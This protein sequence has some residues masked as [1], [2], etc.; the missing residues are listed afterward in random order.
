MKKHLNERYERGFIVPSK[1]LT[2]LEPYKIIKM[3]RIFKDY[4]E[5]IRLPFGLFVD[6]KEGKCEVGMVEVGEEGMERKIVERKWE[7]DI[8]NYW[9]DRR[10]EKR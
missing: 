3:P 6:L 1:R 5:C 10:E 9:I 8:W 4:Y 7:G 2:G